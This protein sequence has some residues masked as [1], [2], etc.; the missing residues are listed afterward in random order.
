MTLANATPGHDTIRFNIAGGG[1]RVIALTS[2]LPVVGTPMALLGTTQ[3]G[4]DGRPMVRVDGQGT[5][6]YGFELQHK[7]K[8]SGLSLTRFTK[9]A[10]MIMAGGGGSVIEFSHVGTDRNGAAGDR[11]SVV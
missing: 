6:S 5:G 9:P 10:V 3:P 2:S 1:E 11:K 7:S 8:I 4:Y